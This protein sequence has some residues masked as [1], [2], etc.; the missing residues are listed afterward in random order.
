MLPSKK[1]GQITQ[2]IKEDIN[3]IDKQ[4]ISITSDIWPDRNKGNSY[5]NLEIFYLEKDGWDISN[6]LLDFK[7]FPLKKTCEN[8]S[9][10]L[11]SILD[12][13]NLDIYQIPFTTDS[14]SNLVCATK[15]TIRF[16]CF[17][18]RLHTTIS[19]AYVNTLNVKNNLKV[20]DPACHAL[21]S[22]IKSSPDI[23]EY[24]P[25]A[26]AHGGKTRP[27]GSLASMYESILT[28]STDKTLTLKNIL[29]EKE[30][31]HLLEAINLNL[32]QQMLKS[33]KLFTL[34]FDS[35]EMSKL[36]NMQLALP[37]YYKIKEE[38]IPNSNN[39]PLFKCFKKIFVKA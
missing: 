22:F 12:Y 24:L 20:L 30:N 39:D 1:A 25:K 11:T 36:P 37:I 29:K 10:M 18:P 21:V 38:S 27:W 17:C 16:A 23:Q 4:A 15:D 7:V 31:S 3:N 13:F 8:I 6:K 2:Y 9:E 35:F 26:L 33:L 14:A 34:I 28:N 5:I 19:E 32:L